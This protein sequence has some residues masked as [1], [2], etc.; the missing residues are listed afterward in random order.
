M[1]LVGFEQSLSPKLRLW[2]YQIQLLHV[3]EQC[4]HDIL[5][6]MIG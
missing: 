1:G 3:K 5:E 6:T 4:A 2:N